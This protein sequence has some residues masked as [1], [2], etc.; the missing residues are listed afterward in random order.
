MGG[1]QHSRGL[2]VHVEHN[3]RV[4]TRSPGCFCLLTTA[5]SAAFA[6]DTGFEAARAGSPLHTFDM[7][8]LLLLASVAD[9]MAAVAV[10]AGSK[11]AAVAAEIES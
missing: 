9:S 5:A 4:S 7:A 10:V 8:V 2:S 6:L 11:V 3:S 1:G